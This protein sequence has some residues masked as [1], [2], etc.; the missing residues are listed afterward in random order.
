MTSYNF[1]NNESD[2]IYDNFVRDGVFG[3]K[4]KIKHKVIL[5]KGFS[6]VRLIDSPLSI[7]Y[8]DYDPDRNAYNSTS[9]VSDYLDV[10]DTEQIPG[11]NKIGINAFRDKDPIRNSKLNIFDSRINNAWINFFESTGQ[12]DLVCVEMTE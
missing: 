10:N 7:E 2:V 8:Y 1:C 4:T 11:L 9:D 3:K 6:L 5:C 12:G